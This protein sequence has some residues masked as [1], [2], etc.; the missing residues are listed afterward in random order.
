MAAALIKYKLIM[1]S[2]EKK[3][4]PLIFGRPYPF[5]PYLLIWLNLQ[6]HTGGFWLQYNKQNS[7]F[8]LP[9]A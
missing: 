6:K 9:T 4:M 5:F 7:T 2:S 3:K 8:G 1:G